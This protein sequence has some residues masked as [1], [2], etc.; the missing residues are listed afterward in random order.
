MNFLDALAQITAES[1]TTMWI[2]IGVTL[3]LVLIIVLVL[4]FRKKPAI[5]DQSKDKKVALEGVSPEKYE[6]KKDGL[7]LAEVK[8]SKK[9]EAEDGSKEAMRELRKERRASEQTEKALEEEHVKIADSVTDSSVGADDVFASLFGDA[10]KSGVSF[11]MDD[12]I[13]GVS[14]SDSVI[15]TLGSGLIRL[16]GSKAEAVDSSLDELTK[17]LAEKAKAEKKTID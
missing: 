8:A 1:S 16:D 7:S 12:E 6:E 4:V 5:T 14:P 11:S 2:A 10:K 17:R 15:P 9:L 13:E 3:A